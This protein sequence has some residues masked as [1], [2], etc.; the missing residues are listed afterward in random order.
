MRPGTGSETR[1]DPRRAFADPAHWKRL[2][3]ADTPKEF[4]KAII[5]IV[6]HE[7]LQ[8]RLQQNGFKTAEKYY[9]QHVIQ[10]KLDRLL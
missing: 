4:A 8:K 6:T 9:S 3:E 10:K 1:K 5:D 2:N 7:S